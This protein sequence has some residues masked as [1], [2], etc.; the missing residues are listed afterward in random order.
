MPAPKK[1][2]YQCAHCGRRNEYEQKEMDPTRK[3][4]KVQEVSGR[5]RIAC[6]CGIM[7]KLC[8]TKE[9]LKVLWNSKANKPYASEVLSAEITHPPT[10]GME[11]DTVH[12][13]G[14]PF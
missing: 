4:F 1:D 14:K 12:G 9:H 6:P 10:R 3:G 7:T 13:K 5:Y 11:P 2:F 8:Q